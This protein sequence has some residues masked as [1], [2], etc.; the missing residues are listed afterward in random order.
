MNSLRLLELRFK[1]EV[2]FNP[3]KEQETLRFVLVPSR[4]ALVTTSF[5]LLVVRPGAPSSV[6]V[7]RVSVMGPIGPDQTEA[8]WHDAELKLLAWGMLNALFM[9][10]SRSKNTNCK[11]LRALLLVTRALLLVAEGIATRS[12][13]HFF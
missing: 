11:K 10:R 1:K 8:V 4:N 12:K 3:L 7:P 13:G 2:Y 9:V 6:L 5:L